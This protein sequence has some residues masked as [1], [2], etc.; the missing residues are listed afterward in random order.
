[1]AFQNDMDGVKDRLDRGILSVDEANVEMIRLQGV[2]LISNK[3]PASVRKALNAAVKSG[4]L[5]HM[6]KEGHKPEAYFHPNAIWRA[7]E[8]RNNVER[9]II[10]CARNVFTKG[11]DDICI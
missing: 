10:M 9:E 11:F 2:R 6:K 5:G 8:K 1:M 4:R 7:K 3:L